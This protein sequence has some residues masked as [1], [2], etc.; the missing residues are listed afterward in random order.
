MAAVRNAD[1]S[2]QIVVGVRQTAHR[3]RA[4]HIVA[5]AFEDEAPCVDATKSFQSLGPPVVVDETFIV[6]AAAMRTIEFLPSFFAFIDAM[7]GQVTGKPG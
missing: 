6:L 7:T 1:R 3:V 2:T 5:L 4:R